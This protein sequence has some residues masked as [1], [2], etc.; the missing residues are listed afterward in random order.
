MDILVYYG[1]FGQELNATNLQTMGILA[2]RSGY[3]RLTPYYGH[4]VT[5]SLRL[6]SEMLEWFS[7]E[8]LYV[9]QVPGIIWTCRYICYRCSRI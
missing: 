3:L 8:H 5:G 4:V 2:A 7:T 6:F 9:Q 1:L